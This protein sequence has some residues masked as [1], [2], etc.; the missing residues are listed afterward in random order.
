M[1]VRSGP[2]YAA[3]EKILACLAIGLIFPLLL[4][5][6][7]V[8][9]WSDR[10]IYWNVA[11]VSFAIAFLVYKYRQSGEGR[12]PLKTHLANAGISFLILCGV[13]IVYLLI[14]SALYALI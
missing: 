14:L 3:V 10:I 1:S 6:F 2:M 7:R 13:A 8:T 11:V 12:I 4:Y 9:P 5:R